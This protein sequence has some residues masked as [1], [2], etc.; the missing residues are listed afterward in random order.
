MVVSTHMDI[1][2]VYNIYVNDVLVKTFDYYAFIAGRG[3]ITSVTGERYLPRG[4]FNRF[5][6]YVD[7]IVEYGSA[8]IKFEY[9][10]PGTLVP[11]NGFVI[12]F[13]EFKPA[14]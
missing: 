6:M 11:N 9:T 8:K 7:N 3:I 4:R 12:D 10:G 13:I 5:D 14:K 1:G 2:G